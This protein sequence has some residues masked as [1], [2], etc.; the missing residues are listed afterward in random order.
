ML[1][2]FL[3]TFVFLLFVWLVFFKFKWLKFTK[4]W[5]VISLFFAAH[6][7]LIFVIGLRFV[8]PFS[9]NVKVVQHTIQLIPRLPEPTLV[10]AVLVQ[11]DVP[12]KKGQPLFQFDR[13]PY[14]YQ[15]RQLEA[16][17]EVAS[18]T[19]MTAKYKVDQL[20][21]ELAA[22]K[23]DVRMYKADLEGAEQKVVKSKSELEYSKYQQQLSQGLAQ[24]GAGPEEDAQKW[25]AQTHATE[26]AVL[27]S[28]AGADRS[29]LKYESQW[30]GVNTNVATATAE[31]KESEAAEKQAVATIPSVKAQLDLARYYLDNTLLVAPEDGH[32]VNLQVQPGMVAGI[33]RVGGIASF[34]VDSDRYLLATFNQETLKYVKIGQPVEVALDLDPGQ[35]FG[36]KVDS[37]W[38]ANGQGQYLPSDIIPT[39]DPANPNQPQP[40]GEFAVKIYPTNPS[41]VG[42]PIGAQGAAAIYTSGGGFAVLR[43]IAIRMHSWFNWL[44]PMPF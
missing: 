10:T 24:K 41:K 27:E 23:Q 1:V 19:A 44:Y 21:A 20:K 28:I 30:E 42:L 11:P 43:K 9:T 15:V 32:I 14:E 12:V 31:L 37:I 40:Q 33:V 5:G 8:A 38:W 16:Q 18:A 7:F 35:I 25:E 22:A 39:F 4:T 34:I 29:R 36:A 6:L 26:A 3:I 17:L 13:R 2:A